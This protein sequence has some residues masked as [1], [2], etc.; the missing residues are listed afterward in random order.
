MQHEFS[1][2]VKVLLFC[3]FA[4]MFIYPFR[5]AWRGKHHPRSYQRLYAEM[6]PV[7]LVIYALIALALIY[8]GC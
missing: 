7:H 8:K 3:A 4:F 1:P 6:W 5:V 2:A